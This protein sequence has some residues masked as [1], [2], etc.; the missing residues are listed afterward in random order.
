L[1]KYRKAAPFFVTVYLL[2]INMSQFHKKRRKCW[3]EASNLVFVI[4]PPLAVGG[5]SCQRQQNIKQ[6]AKSRANIIY[7]TSFASLGCTTKIRR[8]S[9]WKL[10]SK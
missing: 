7:S 9:T 1:Q 2:F 8:F 5:Y 10:K 3:R 4:S 6:E